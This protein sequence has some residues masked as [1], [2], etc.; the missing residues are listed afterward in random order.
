MVL[1]GGPDDDQQV[2][3]GGGEHGERVGAGGAG[4]AEFGGGTCGDLGHEERRGGADGGGNEHAP[5]PSRHTP[6]RAPQPRPPARPLG[7]A[8]GPHDVPDAGAHGRGP[9]RDSRPD[10]RSAP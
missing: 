8:P 1:V 9:A 3:P 10:P 6:P 5:Q 4:F 2:G 7:S